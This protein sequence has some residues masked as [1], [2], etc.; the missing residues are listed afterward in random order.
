MAGGRIEL[1]RLLRACSSMPVERA[2]A[3]FTAFEAWQVQALYEALS[4]DLGLGARCSFDGLQRRLGVTDLSRVQRDPMIFRRG[5]ITR[6]ELLRT[7]ALE[8][9]YHL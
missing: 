3:E 5:S 7:T 9:H 1:Q 8:A 2:M 6:Y 4:S